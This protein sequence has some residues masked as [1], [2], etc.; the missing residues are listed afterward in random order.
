[1]VLRTSELN[2]EVGKLVSS[3]QE[4]AAQA[5]RPLISTDTSVNTHRNGRHFPLVLVVNDTHY[6][7]PGVTDITAEP[8]SRHPE[9]HTCTYIGVDADRP[10]PHLN[11]NQGRASQGV[12]RAVG[13]AC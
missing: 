2:R 8:H 13:L 11:K 3:V 4:G 12:L 1:M 6:S 7:F 10:S 5:I 9:D